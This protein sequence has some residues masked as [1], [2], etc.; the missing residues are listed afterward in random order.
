MKRKLAT[1]IASL[2]ATMA[3]AVSGASAN[4]VYSGHCSATP[5]GVT[6]SYGLTIRA[7]YYV[8]VACSAPSR[9]QWVSVH[10]WLWDGTAGRTVRSWSGRDYIY[11]GVPQYDDDDA[12]VTAGHY[13]LPMAQITAS[14]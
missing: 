4:T 13:Y 1:L 11:P 6:F 10:L 14:Y 7:E 9:G 3:L 12:I 5:S 2:V 8:R